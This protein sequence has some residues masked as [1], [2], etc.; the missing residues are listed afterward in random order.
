MADDDGRAC[1]CRHAALQEGAGGVS[2]VG[3][4]IAGGVGGEAVAREVGGVDVPP[5]GEEGNEVEPGL[6]PAAEAVEEEERTVA[7]RA[8][9]VGL[10]MT[11]STALRTSLNIVEAGVRVVEG[12]LLQHGC[13]G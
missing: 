7:G 3:C 8:H 10:R 9:F 11:L 1:G 2:V 5:E 12:L 6:P 13:V 4:A